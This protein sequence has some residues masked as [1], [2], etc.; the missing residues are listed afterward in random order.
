MYLVKAHFPA[1]LPSSAVVS[2]PSSCAAVHSPPRPSG[3][4]SCRT[5]RERQPQEAM[6]LPSLRVESGQ[7]STLQ[8]AACFRYAVF[9][10]RKRKRV[11][12][13]LSSGL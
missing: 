11:S 3:H 1:L 13:W 4:R 2:E 12:R 6:K 8:V 7:K 9:Y 5:R 10:E